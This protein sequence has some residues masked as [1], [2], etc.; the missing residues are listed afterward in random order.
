MKENFEEKFMDI[1]SGLISLC[2]ELTEGKMDKIYAYAYISESCTSFNAFFRKNGE[3]ITLGKLG[4]DM[5]SMMEFLDLG[6]DDLDLVI[7]LF[8]DNEMQCPIEM[9][10]YYDVKTGGYKADYRYDAYDNEEDMDPD[11]LFLKWREE[12]AKEA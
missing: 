4:I 8:E 7:E 12:T 9:K 2:M 11:E 10:M 1:Q 6:A 5:D 3:I